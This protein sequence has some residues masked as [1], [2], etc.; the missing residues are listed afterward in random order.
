MKIVLP[1]FATACVVALLAGSAFAADG[2]FVVQAGR[3]VTVDGDVLAEGGS[4]FVSGGRIEDVKPGHVN[5]WGAPVRKY[6]DAWLMPGFVEAHSQGGLWRGSNER[7]PNTP[8]VSVLDGL[9]PLNDYFTDLLRD[10]VTTVF[11]VP[12]DQ[13]MLGGQ[14]M[15]VKPTGRT[16]EEM[17][18]R[19][20][21]G[22]KIAFAPRNGTS[23]MAQLAELRRALTS[24]R[25]T[26]SKEVASDPDD[27]TRSARQVAMSALLEGRLPAVMTCNAPVDVV[28][29]FSIMDEFGL[30]G[31]VRLGGSGRKALPMLAKRGIGVLLPDDIEPLERD[32]ETGEE[33]RRFLAA[34]CKA[35]GVPVVIQANEASPYGMRSLWYQAAVAVSQGLARDEAFRAVSLEPAKVLGV[36]DRVGSITKGK[37]ANLVLWSGDPMDPMSHVDLVWIEG[38]EVYDR[39]KDRKLVRLLEGAAPSRSAA[40]ER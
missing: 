24:A 35:A 33:E 7:A 25:G 3:V 11:V 6:E 39:M 1:S 26:E 21:A 30:Q 40:E 20:D 36:D 32:A 23:R 22:L 16:A 29:A 19:R 2:E 17:I 4:V 8:F 34:E 12:G 38:D 9:D 10:G 13:T 27:P 14:G 28:N 37:D 31:F 15:V 18:V 5:P